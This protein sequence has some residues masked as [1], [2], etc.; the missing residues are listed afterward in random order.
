MT[1]KGHG[2]RP[3]WPAVIRRMRP[4]LAAAATMFTLSVVLTGCNGDDAATKADNAAA[5]SESPSG[6]PSL[7]SDL[8]SDTPSDL[9]TDLPTDVPTT[10]ASEASG[11]A[12]DGCTVVTAEMIQS[13]FGANPGQHMSQPASLGDPNASDCYYV[14]GDGTI[15]VETTSRAD[16]DMPESGYSYEGLPGA[17]SVDGADRGWAYILPGQDDSSVTSSLILVKGQNGVQLTI[18]LNDHPYTID[19]LQKFA[20]DVLAN[21]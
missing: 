15:V 19:D 6:T 9:S 2:L 14:G 17:E 3:P 7:H 11:A 16:Q 13:D 20:G 21:L 1:Q 4:A 10:G 12:I 5:A 18:Q 8:P